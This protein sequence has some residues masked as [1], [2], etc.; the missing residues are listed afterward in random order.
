MTT[1]KSARSLAREYAR[2]LDTLPPA[3]RS[4][5]IAHLQ[6]LHER[7][8]REAGFKAFLDHP[9][10]TADE[11]LGSLESMAPRRFS[12][13]VGRVVADV[14]RR[15]MTFLFSGI[16]EEMQRL[17]DR[18]T[19]VHPVEVASAAPLSEQ[20]RTTLT[21]RLKAYCG[22]DVRVRF[23]ADLS[24]M[25]GFSIHAGDTVLDNS[26]RTGL[27]HIRRRLEAVSST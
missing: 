26:I 10:I 17:S 14:V 15:R 27:E 1:V 6:A 2:A 20:Q 3:E 13:V 22:G 5:V 25:A 21:A 18:A 4:T 24:L 19:G 9:A 12:P 7:A 8:Q 16:A 11:K 23:V